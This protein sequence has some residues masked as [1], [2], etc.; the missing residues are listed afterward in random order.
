MN[1]WILF[2]LLFVATWIL[3][4]PFLGVTGG[5]VHV[6]ILTVAIALTADMLGV[7][8]L[9]PFRLKKTWSLLLVIGAW[10]FLAVTYGWLAMFGGFLPAGTV[11]AIPGTT[12]T[13]T[14]TGNCQAGVSSEILGTSATLSLNAY[15]QES[16]TPYSSAVDLTTNCN[17]Y[18]DSNSA[19]NYVGP[20]S[21]TSAGNLS[22]FKV[23]DKIVGYCG[24]SSY[25][26]DPIDQCVAGQQESVEISTHAAVAESNM[27][28]TVYDNTGGTTLDATSSANYGD[29]NLTLGAGGEDTIYVK[30][31]NNVG[32]KAY[33]FCGWGVA[34]FYNVSAVRPQNVEA[35]YTAIATPES[36]KNIDIEV[37]TTSNTLNKDYTVYKADSAIMLHQ[38]DTLTEQF[39][40]EASDTNDPIA[41]GLTTGSDLNGFAI[42]AKDCQWA[43]GGD[44]AE[45]FDIAT[46][47]VSQTDVGVDETETSPRGKQTGVQVCVI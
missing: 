19:G 17:F 43:R 4:A 12:G 11:A 6:L 3:G 8:K 27:Q 16:N 23:G 5:L 20:T 41:Y 2:I 14:A 45:H 34:T 37:N 38:W 35:T 31:K 29:Y 21:D 32:N 30:L 39:E 10:G 24:G 25:Y 36:M 22:G 26:T 33:Q 9:F 28:I 47:D 15:D 44:G 7:F 18:R 46:V 42:L 1:K 40:V 13:A